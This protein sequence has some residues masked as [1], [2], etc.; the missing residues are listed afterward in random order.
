MVREEIAKLMDQAERHPK[1]EVEAALW[2]LLLQCRDAYAFNRVT[3]MKWPTTLKKHTANMQV[4]QDK[5]RAEAIKRFPQ[6]SILTKVQAGFDSNMVG[7][8][9][10]HPHQIDDET[11]FTCTAAMELFA[12][13]TRTI[14]GGVDISWEPLEAAD[15]EARSSRH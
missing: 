1:T 8:R 9:I 6:F 5:V 10:V 4:S 11:S 3:P 7:F 15:E 12:K 14:K 13:H 2:L